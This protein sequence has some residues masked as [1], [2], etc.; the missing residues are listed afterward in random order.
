MVRCI[1]ALSKRRLVSLWR[2]FHLGRAPL[3]FANMKTPQVRYTI[4]VL[5]LLYI[6][7]YYVGFSACF[8]KRL[9]QHILGEGAHVTRRFGVASIK[10]TEEVTSLESAKAREG[11][12][13]DFLLF[14]GVP[15][16]G[17]GRCR[18]EHNEDMEK[19]PTRVVDW[20]AP[21]RVPVSFLRAMP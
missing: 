21:D 15:A 19:R 8:S 2:S 5:S 4:Y 18:L 13:V 9:T 6:D 1:V 16:W 12:L 7:G 11:E 20:H 14:Q 10:H 3:P 17:G